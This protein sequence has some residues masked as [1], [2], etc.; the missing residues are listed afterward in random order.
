MQ[1]CYKTVLQGFNE[2]EW[3]PVAGDPLVA[4]FPHCH[5]L[6]A[7]SSPAAPSFVPACWGPSAQ[8]VSASGFAAAPYPLALLVGEQFPLEQVRDIQQ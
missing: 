5:H 7:E 2:Q 1:G 3:S 4:L 8:L 6:P